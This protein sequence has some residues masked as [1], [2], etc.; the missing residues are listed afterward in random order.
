VRVITNKLEGDQ[1]FEGEVELRGMVVGTLTAAP[2]SS[3]AVRGMLVGPLIVGLGATVVVHGTVNG[4]VYNRG[5]E[6]TIWGT[7]NGDVHT[8][9]GT[10]TVQSEAVVRG[11][12]T[13][14][15]LHI[16]PDALV[17]GSVEERLPLGP[18]SRP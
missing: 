12:T 13:D 1:A 18:T 10:T 6:V 14:S 8:L 16:G 11:K 5:G 4:A 15:R 9:A 7:V 2:D 17:V 3:I